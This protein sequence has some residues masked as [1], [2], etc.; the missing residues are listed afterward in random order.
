M[1]TDDLFQE[2]TDR[3]IGQMESGIAPWNKPWNSAL[4]GFEPSL[5]HNI[6]GR[7]YRGANVFWLM[8]VAQ[9]RGYESPVWLT[10]KQAQET[11]GSVRKGEKGTA[12]FFWHFD[13]KLNEETGKTEQ[14]CWAKAYTVF[15]I[16]QC[17]GVKAPQAKPR[18]QAE[19]VAEADALICA[20]GAI[21]KHGGD[22]AC[23][24]PSLD[25][26]RLPDREAFASV[27][28][29]YGTAFH[30]LGHWTGS[31]KRLNRQFGKRFGDDAYAFEELVAELTA[32][33]VNGAL[34]LANPARTDHA[35]YLKHWMKILKADRR[36]FITAA[37]KAQAAADFILK[38]QTEEVA[39]AA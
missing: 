27:D 20:T 22:A 6:A 26:V 39:E 14:T 4:A 30:E 35:A 25:I 31:E 28:G 9:A 16:A 12:V 33:F 36:A 21:I 17:D 38:A 11:G 29:Y 7:A 15:N 10:F 3:L 8:M 34:G 19:T 5:P 13:R 32:A 1:K 18:T 2:I 24:I 23:Y 37:G